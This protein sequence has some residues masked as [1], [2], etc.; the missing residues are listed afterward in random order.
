MNR[1]ASNAIVVREAYSMMLQEMEKSRLSLALLGSKVE[2]RDDFSTF[3]NLG[4][5]LF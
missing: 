5:S 1:R 2:R 3:Y 4:D